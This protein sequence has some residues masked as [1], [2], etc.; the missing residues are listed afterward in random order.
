MS[1]CLEKMFKR[2][3]AAIWER[4]ELLQPAWTVFRRTHVLATG[5][6]GEIQ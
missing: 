2:K 3:Y 5:D 6:R 1:K 4:P